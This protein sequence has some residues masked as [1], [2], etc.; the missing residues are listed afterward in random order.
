MKR[1]LEQLKNRLQVRQNVWAVELRVILQS[2][3]DHCFH[4]AVHF[5]L[6][7]VQ[8]ETQKVRAETKL[9]INLE[10]SRISD[11]VR[12]FVCVEIDWNDVC[13]HNCRVGEKLILCFSCQFTEQ[14]KKLMEATSEF[15]HKVDGL[16]KFCN[17]RASVG[18][19]SWLVVFS[20]FVWMMTSLEVRPGARQHGDQQEDGHPSGFAQN[21]PGVPQIGDGALP[22]RWPQRIYVHFDHTVSIA[23]AAHWK[24]V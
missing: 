4:E 20:T 3:L 8:E 22:R 5:H 11:M 12:A 10:S 23:T 16:N 18:S 17:Q 15:H 6:V 2:K 7:H 24:R 14:E 19:V 21:R 1:E 13:T 9:D